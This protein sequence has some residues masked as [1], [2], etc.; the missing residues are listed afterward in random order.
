MKNALPPHFHLSRFA[1]AS[2]ALVLSGLLAAATP[3]AQITPATIVKPN[4]QVHSKP[5]FA[6]PAVTTLAENAQVNV[7]GQQG[8]WFKLGLDGGKSGYVLVNQKRVA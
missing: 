6:S 1:L 8:L 4:V 2:A 7:T 3:T 5:D